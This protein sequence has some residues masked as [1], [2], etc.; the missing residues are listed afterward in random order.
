MRLAAGHIRHEDVE[1]RPRRA[2]APRRRSLDSKASESRPAPMLTHGTASRAVGGRPAHP[3]RDGPT[4]IAMSCATGPT[5]PLPFQDA[6][7]TMAVTLVPAAGR[8]GLR[9][10]SSRS[11]PMHGCRWIS[12]SLGR[13]SRSRIRSGCPSVHDQ[14]ARPTC[15][16]SCRVCASLCLL[17]EWTEVNAVEEPPQERLHHEAWQ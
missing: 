3:R 5:W 6:L 4:V 15:L 17:D 16:T 10:Q 11:R 9:A 7:I 12:S 8:D 2:R 14:V 13:H 1:Q